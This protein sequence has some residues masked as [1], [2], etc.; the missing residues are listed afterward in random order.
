MRYNKC[1]VNQK[2]ETVQLKGVN[3]GAWLVRE[4]WLNPD[5]IDTTD[6]EPFVNMEHY[7][8]VSSYSIDFAI[9]FGFTKK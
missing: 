8:G 5:D 3:L 6:D 1:I 2:G 7:T 9:I 4:D